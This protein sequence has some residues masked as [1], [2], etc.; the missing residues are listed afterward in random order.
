MSETQ[1]TQRGGACARTRAADGKTGTS[2]WLKTKARHRRPRMS[3][4]FLYCNVCFGWNADASYATLSTMR[5]LPLLVAALLNSACVSRSELP[6]QTASDLPCVPFGGASASQ[7]WLT[8]DYQVVPI[9]AEHQ[10]QMMQRLKRGEVEDVDATVA[11]T[12][13]GNVVLPKVAHYYLIRV[14]YIGEAPQGTVPSGVSMGADVDT[15]GAAYVTTF[16]LGSWPARSEFAAVLTSPT[17]LKRL[18]STCG[19]AE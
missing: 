11:K 10:P 9:L 2:C 14:G 19:A 6:L 16:R 12:L 4:Q 3:A 13:T 1:Q 18:V 17:H 8:G 5:T 7:K 15:D